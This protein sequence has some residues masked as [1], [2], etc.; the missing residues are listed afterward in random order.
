VSLKQLASRNRS[1]SIA[2]TAGQSSRA[3][4]AV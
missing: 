3:V 4:L 1:R 2:Q